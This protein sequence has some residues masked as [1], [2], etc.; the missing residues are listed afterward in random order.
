M[1][2]LIVDMKIGMVIVPN[3]KE[4]LPMVAF[5]DKENYYESLYRV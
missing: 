5:I 2:I 3:I 4:I 1:A